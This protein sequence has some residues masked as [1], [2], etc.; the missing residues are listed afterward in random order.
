MN[1]KL[2]KAVKWNTYT[3][4]SNLNLS[5]FAMELTGRLKGKES[6]ENECF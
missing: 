2:A 5:S 4:V 1:N 6:G 3:C